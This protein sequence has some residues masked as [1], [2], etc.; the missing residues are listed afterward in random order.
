[1]QSAVVV[2]VAYVVQVDIEPLVPGDQMPPKQ[3]IVSDN[4]V[5]GALRPH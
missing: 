3:V 2:T 4:Y 5:W 1:M